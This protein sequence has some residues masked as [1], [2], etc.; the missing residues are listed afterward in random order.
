[1]KMD[2]V[3]VINDWETNDNITRDVP[4]NLF[5]VILGI[6]GDLNYAMLFHLTNHVD[7]D[8]ELWFKINS[9]EVCFILVD[10]P[11][12][13][14]L[15]FE[16]DTKVWHYI[17]CLGKPRLKEKYFSTVNISLQYKEIQRVIEDQIREII[18]RMLWSL[19]CCIYGMSCY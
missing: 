4:K 12:M 1:M 2:I 15:V 10:F 5:W 17:D 6:I 9:V 16:N 14:S 11:F 18:I 7:V 3:N 8:K 19:W 13:T